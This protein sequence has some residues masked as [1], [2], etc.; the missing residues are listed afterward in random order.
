MLR[1]S[2]VLP[3]PE[4]LTIRG[5]EPAE[6]ETVLRWDTEQALVVAWSARTVDLRRL[7]RLGFV[8]RRISR[9]ARTGRLHG[10]EAILPLEQFR[11]GRKRQA[12]RMP[13]G[14]PYK[15]APAAGD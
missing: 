12:S 9:D 11:W 6:R 2:P 14:T 10:I 13:V 5:Y 1:P 8:P 15:R 7:Q 4:D 3:W